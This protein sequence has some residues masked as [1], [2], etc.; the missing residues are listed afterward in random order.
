MFTSVRGTVKGQQPDA[1][2]FSLPA[3]RVSL[4]RIP[5]VPALINAPKVLPRI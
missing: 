5:R 3:L 2:L 4:H 1:P